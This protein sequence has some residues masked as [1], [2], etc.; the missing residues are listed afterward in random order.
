MLLI[1]FDLYAG[2][3]SRGEATPQRRGQAVGA[4]AVGIV[5]AYPQR[6]NAALQESR[7]VFAQAPFALASR[8]VEQPHVGVAHHSVEHRS[9][10]VRGKMHHPPT[11]RDRLPRLLGDLVAVRRIVAGR[12][13]LPIRRRET[14]GELRE[15][16]RMTRRAVELDQKPAYRRTDE[17]RVERRRQC[18][19]QVERPGVVT[20]VGGKDLRAVAEKRPVWR[21]NAIAA[22]LARHE[23]IGRA[24]TSEP[25]Y[26]FSSGSF[27]NT[28]RVPSLQALLSA[29]K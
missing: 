9:E 24:G 15:A 2:V 26:H 19:R 11:G 1:R 7:P 18:A 22:M 23:H 14:A 21:R 17:R 20:A 12:D 13:A 25:G 28:S 6:R 29:E 16:L 10:R 3:M 4:A 8:I 5:A 27:L